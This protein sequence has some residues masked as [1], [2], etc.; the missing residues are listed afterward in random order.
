MRP[1]AARA[2]GRRAAIWVAAGYVSLPVV[3]VGSVLISTD[4]IMFPFLALALWAWLEGLSQAKGARR[5]W[6]AL[7]AGAALGLGFMA[8]YAAVYFVLGAGLAAAVL[9]QARPG[10]RMAGLAI[11]AFLVVIAPNILWNAV[12][13]FPTVS[14]TLDNVGW[15]KAPEKKTGLHFGGMAEFILSQF[16]VFGPVAMAILLGLVPRFGRLTPALRFC[17]IVALP[18]LALVTVQALLSRAYANW[19]AAAFVAATIPVFASV[20]TRPRLGALALAVNAVFCLI[21][22]VAVLIPGET[23]LGHSKRPVMARYLGRAATSREILGVAQKAGIP[24]IVAD[25]RDMLADLFYTARKSGIAIYAAPPPECGAGQGCFHDHYQMTRQVPAD[26]GGKVLFAS[27]GP[28]PRCASEARP[29]ATLAGSPKIYRRWTVKL[30]AV[31]GDCW[32][33]P[34]ARK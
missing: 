1:F 7:A 25:N 23:A 21:V 3:A 5:D 12:N 26:L 18:I 34:A 13:H 8:K 17:M 16:G 33:K 2:A 14:H 20:A 22:P 28:A 30:Y 4:T 9:P 27:D 11:L 6:L 29:M 19:A 31:P 32:A 10:L 15:I 24:A